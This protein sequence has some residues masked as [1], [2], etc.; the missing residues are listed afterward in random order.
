MAWVCHCILILSL[1]K[2]RETAGS[3]IEKV[4]FPMDLNGVVYVSFGQP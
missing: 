3:L 2:G 1:C 4:S